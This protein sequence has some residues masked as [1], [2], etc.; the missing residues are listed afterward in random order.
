MREHDEQGEHQREE[1]PAEAARFEETQEKL[2]DE[3][4]E[5]DAHRLHHAE[6]LGDIVIREGAHD[7]QRAGE[8]R[9]AAPS[10]DAQR[11][12]VKQR[13]DDALKAQVDREIRAVAAAAQAG[14]Q[15]LE[16]RDDGAVFVAVVGKQTGERI[17]GPSGQHI[18]DIVALD[19]AR[20][21]KRAEPQ[22]VR[23]AEQQD[24]RE[25][26]QRP[27]PARRAPLF[28]CLHRSAHPHRG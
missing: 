21:S 2:H 25:V 8:K 14:F 27:P 3:Q 28:L 17:D 26:G 5:E 12:P 23:R 16:Q 13:R 1:E 18:A 6:Y 19:D 15:K 24:E 22:G 9:D 11:Q 7:E 4:Q 10:A 20:A